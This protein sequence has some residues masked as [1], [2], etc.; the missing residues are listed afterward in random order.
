MCGNVGLAA[1]FIRKRKAGCL[2][3][4]LIP[5]KCLQTRKEFEGD[6]L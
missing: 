4:N 3:G 6:T 5:L 1:P 2:N